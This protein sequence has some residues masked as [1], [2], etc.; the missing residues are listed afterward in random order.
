MISMQFDAPLFIF[1]YLQFN[2][3][4]IFNFKQAIDN[5]FIQS[6]K[7]NIISFCII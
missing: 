3:S 1:N 6:R 5:F 7:P 4:R 2:E